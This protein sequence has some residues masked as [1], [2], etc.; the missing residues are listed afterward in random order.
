MERTKMEIR[1]M[2]LI[3]AEERLTQLI[4]EKEI[5]IETI[6]REGENK[7]SNL[8]NKKEML[9]VWKATSEEVEIWKKEVFR[10]L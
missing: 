5:D 10:L 6:E 7:Y 2:I 3:L 8:E 9:S 4:R 1:K